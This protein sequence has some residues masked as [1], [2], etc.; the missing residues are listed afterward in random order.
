MSAI[1]ISYI[2]SDIFFIKF[3]ESNIKVHWPLTLKTIL[4][5]WWS[6]TG[7]FWT[8]GCLITN[9]RGDLDLTKDISR[10]FYNISK[11]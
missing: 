11:D 4:F 2:R 6:I 9:F 10:A 1:I 5:G 8:I 3:D 7:F